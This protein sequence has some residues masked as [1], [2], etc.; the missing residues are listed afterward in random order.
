MSHTYVI[1]EISS[2]SFAEIK[3]ALEVEYK[4][5]LHQDNESGEV[6]D[7]HGLALATTS[8]KNNQEKPVNISNILHNVMDSISTYRFYEAGLDR[9]QSTIAQTVARQIIEEMLTDYLNKN[10]KF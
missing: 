6:I 9:K 10:R 5:K 2:N 4:E 1:L 8:C 3:E 7:M